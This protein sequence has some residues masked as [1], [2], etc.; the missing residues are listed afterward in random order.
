MEEAS[1]SREKSRAI[2][3]EKKGSCFSPLES[4]R[5]AMKAPAINLEECAKFKGTIASDYKAGKAP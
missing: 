1:L 5:G 3:L 2:S 4:S